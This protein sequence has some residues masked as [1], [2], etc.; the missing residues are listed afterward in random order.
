MKKP[1]WEPGP[2]RV[3][4][5]NLNRFARFAREQSGNEDLR[6][7]AALYEF[8]IRHP[9]RFWPLVWEFCGIRASGTFHETLVAADHPADVRWFPGIR[10][11]VAQNLLRFRDE[12]C[13]LIGRDAA[14][15]GYEI[16]YAQL[17]LQVARV[18]AALRARGI[19]AGDTVAGL[20]R[21]GSEPVVAML[22]SV[23]V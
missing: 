1:I 7:Y 9:E 15:A 10:L 3:E 17:Q 14:G 20:L 23:A 5:A 8:S 19:G 6:G 2:E 13:A 4:R 16:S 22:A 12:R 18:A 11:N 21:N